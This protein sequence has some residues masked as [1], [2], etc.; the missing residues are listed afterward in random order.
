MA[1]MAR[2][3]L[4]PWNDREMTMVLVKAGRTCWISAGN[5]KYL[6]CST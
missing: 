2:V 3:E 6:D 4:I 5:K 1:R